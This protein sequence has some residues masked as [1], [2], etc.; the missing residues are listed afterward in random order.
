M[1][2]VGA[3]PGRQQQH[4]VL[5]QPRGHFHGAR[6]LPQVSHVR[7]AIRGRPEMPQ[8]QEHCSAGLPP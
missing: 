6:G 3:D 4:E 8:M 7:H 1:R 5:Q 2:V